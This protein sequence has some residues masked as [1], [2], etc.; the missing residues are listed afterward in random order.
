MNRAEFPL[1]VNLGGRAVAWIESE[2]DGW[3][4]SRVSERRALEK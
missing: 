4:H 1:P 2:I 3:I